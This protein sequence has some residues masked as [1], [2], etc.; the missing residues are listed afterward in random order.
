MNDASHKGFSLDPDMA[1][2]FD[3]PEVIDAAEF[4]FQ[5]EIC[6]LED[7]LYE[8]MKACW[9]VIDPAPFADNWHLDAIAE[10]LEHCCFH[11][12]PTPIK[13]LIINIPPRCSKSSILVCFVAWVWAQSI[14]SHTSGPGVQFMCGSYAQNLSLRDSLKVR[15][16]VE[17]NWY[18]ERWPHVQITDDQN[19]KTEFQT[20]AGGYRLSIS[21]GGQTTGHG[22]N[23]IILDDPNNV[24]DMESEADRNSAI[25]WFDGSI[26]TR[27]NNANEGVVIV[28]QQR[29]HEEDITGHILST[30]PEIWTH[31]MLPME[32]EKE[33]A[34]LLY[35]NLIGFEDPRSVDGEL[36]APERF[37]RKAVTALTRRLGPY[38][39]NPAEAPVLMADLTSKPISEIKV[40]DQ[41]VGFGFEGEV[42][43][44]AGHERQSLKIATVKNV[45]VSHAPI[46]KMTLDSGEVIRCTP[47]HRWYR[48]KHRNDRSADKLYGSAVV[49]SKLSRICPTH[50]PKLT[51]EEQRLG[52]WLGGFFDGEGSATM[53]H[54][55]NGHK[56]STQ[57]MFYQGAGRN[58]P[59]C[60]KLESILQHFGFEY[61]MNEDRR[62]D[63]A[64]EQGYGYRTYKLK[65]VGLPTIQK[66]LH[67][68]Q[69]MKWRDRMINGAF[70]SKF[71]QGKE[72][73]VSIVPDG[74]ETVYALETT[75]GNY[76]VWGLASSNS[77]GQLQ[78]RPSPKGGG[79]IKRE[80]WK[81]W[82]L[83]KY[84]ACSYVVAYL[85][86]A[87][88]T[89]EENDPSAM[90]VWGV[91]ED[92]NENPRA[93][94]MYG[95]AGK[96]ELHDLVQKVAQTAKDF[97]IDVLLVENKA[98]G[99]SVAQELRR[100][101][102]WEE[103]NIIMD[104]PKSTDKVGRA[105]SV[106]H[107]FAEGII[108]VPDDRA[109]AQTIITECE[110]FPKGRHDDLVDTVTGAV[111]HLRTL[112]LLMRGPERTAEITESTTFKGNHKS[113][114]LYP[115]TG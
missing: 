60:D 6:R 100:L 18:Q 83:A 62:K 52:G 115:G 66:F 19:T 92:E 42:K 75:T 28:V 32:Y 81:S 7:N 14:N 109:W 24:K 1:K 23:I 63:K 77:A 64:T 48:G 70:R 111:R 13:R 110:Q 73:V 80:Y 74:E 9:H 51:P 94:L 46:V 98:A 47:D 65:A 25:E 93:L 69:P 82:T 84:P 15:R 106:Q 107:L 10:H 68:A 91:Y 59:L 72:R 114:P 89:K 31:L 108:Y 88:T 22:G 37:D 45:F 17:S 78:Q 79:I 34:E 26:S 104:D 86:T 29:V 105:Y 85:D 8:F 99:H 43:D 5:D 12:S 71:I 112:G 30:E 55:T 41:L 11:D 76:V 56:H 44:G 97:K 33:R 40:G 39:C 35:P 57:I 87:Y 67:V 20:T 38:R 53:S 16:L 2:A 36:L 61:S 103:F 96:F 27:L 4:M 101:Y 95:W 54:K 49:G 58:K 90:T 102:R 113:L 21:I 3:L 50:L